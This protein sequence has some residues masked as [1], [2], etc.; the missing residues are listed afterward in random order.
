M[1]TTPFICTAALLAALA[2][3]ALADDDHDHDHDHEEGHVDALLAVDPSG[4][5]VTGG[6]DFDA[7]EVESLNT[8]VYEAEFDGPFSGVWTTDEPGFNAVSDTAGGLPAGYTTLPGSTAV[9]F[10][11]NAFTIGA[12]TANLWHWD[13]S[14][15][16]SFAPVAG[17]TQLEI[18]KSPTA[19]FSSTLDGSDSNVAGFEIETT[20]ADGFLHKHIDF[21]IAN[22]DLSEVD[23]GFYLW[24]LT[25]SAGELETDPVYFVHGLGEHTE[26]AHEAAVDFVQTNVVPE[27][28]S[29]ALLGMG[30]LALLRRRR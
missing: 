21:S 24:S 28:G 10:D 3:S 25:L 9:N 15:A 26:I 11:A 29:L 14:G 6:F 2:G 1:K 8:R 27:P 20:G 12:S 4:K 13:G 5:L 23:D 17:P 30:G 22:T 16:V 19:V 7:G 18:S